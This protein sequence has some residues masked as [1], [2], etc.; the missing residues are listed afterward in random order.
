[1]DTYSLLIWVTNCWSL[2]VKVCGWESGDGEG[3]G[4]RLLI[5]QTK[6]LLTFRLMLVSC[7]GC[8]NLANCSRVVTLRGVVTLSRVITLSR[9]LTLSGVIMGGG[10]HFQRSG[11]S[12]Q[13][14]HS[15]TTSSNQLYW[16][17]NCG[18]QYSHLYCWKFTATRISGPN[19][20]CGLDS[21]TVAENLWT[22]GKHFARLR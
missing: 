3:V 17:L 1:M 19:V 10:G 21:L 5:V 9:V 7:V 8:N 2:L 20:K 15:C 4:T 6:Q 22:A 13:G 12:Q 18:F 16:K 11:H 14:G